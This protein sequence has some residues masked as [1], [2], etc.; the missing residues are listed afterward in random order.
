MICELSS[1]RRLGGLESFIII[2]S[3]KNFPVLDFC[4]EKH[5]R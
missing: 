3:C 5:L 2:L 1:G 4:Q